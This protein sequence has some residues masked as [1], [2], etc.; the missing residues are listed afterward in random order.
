MAAASLT[1]DAA[2]EQP[3]PAKHDD[4]GCQHESMLRADERA[5]HH[6][7]GQVRDVG[8]AAVGL[9]PAARPSTRAVQEAGLCSRVEQGAVQLQA[10]CLT[11]G[12]AQRSRCLETAGRE[13]PLRRRRR[14]GRCALAPSR[15]DRHLRTV[16]L[17]SAKTAPTRPSPSLG[18]KL[19]TAHDL[20]VHDAHHLSSIKVIQQQRRK[21]VEC[22]TL[23]WRRHGPAVTTV[24][25]CMLRLASRGRAGQSGSD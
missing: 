20:A 10:G 7:A 2:D 6:Q 9:Q 18:T 24:V 17:P 13:T 15:A 8:A 12:A 5:K 23:R 11:V 19:L 16:R 25:L 3:S 4:R 1:Q 21:S 22:H 14:R